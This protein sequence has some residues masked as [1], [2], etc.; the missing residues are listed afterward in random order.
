[1]KRMMLAVILGWG[2]VLVADPA[3]ATCRTYTIS[4]PDGR[5]IFCQECCWGN[6]NC[7]LS[8]N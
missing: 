4:G 1:M 6:G 8:C 3:L 5:I 2:L 7:T